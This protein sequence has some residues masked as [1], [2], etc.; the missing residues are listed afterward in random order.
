M[1]GNGG[2]QTVGTGQNATG[3]APVSPLAA[4]PQLLASGSGQAPFGAIIP[5]TNINPLPV[6]P[7]PDFMQA[8]NASQQQLQARQAAPFVP[9]PARPPE[10]TPTPV[11]RRG[12]GGP[13]GGGFGGG[14]RQRNRHVR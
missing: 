9:I 13:G 14:N 12:R 4:L 1:L 7:M 10:V 11:P 5:P 6:P 8:F 2:A 3:A